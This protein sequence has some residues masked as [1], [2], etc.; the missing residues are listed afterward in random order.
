MPRKLYGFDEDGN[1]IVV[2]KYRPAISTTLNDNEW[3]VIHDVAQDGNASQYWSVGD[4]K[5][6]TV[7][8]GTVDQ[9]TINYGVYRAVIIGINHNPTYENPYSIDF[10]I[11]QDSTG[12]EICFRGSTGVRMNTSHITTGGWTGSAMYTTYLPQFYNLLVDNRGLQEAMIA[13]RKYTHNYTGGIDN[14]TEERVTLSEDPRYKMFLMSEF[15]IFGS[16]SYA[17]TYERNKQA[18]YAY[19][20][21]SG[22]AKSKIRYGTETGVANYWWERSAYCNSSYTN[23]FCGVGSGGGADGGS[24]G[25]ARGLCP[26]FRV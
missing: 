24:A 23:A 20:S 11:G 12:K 18:Q 13:P 6:V 10:C 5:E 19:Y 2:G 22:L 25:D 1:K 8:R 14:A 21:S 15:E 3:D 16:R 17:S 26:C 9:M 4:Y 7:I